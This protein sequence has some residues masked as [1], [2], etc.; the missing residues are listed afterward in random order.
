M[1]ASSQAAGYG[2]QHQDGAAEN[3]QGALH[4]DRGVH[5]TRGIDEVDIVITL[6]AVGGSGLDG[7]PP[8]TLKIHRVHGG[9]D[10]G[11]SFYLFDPVELSGVEGASRCGPPP[12]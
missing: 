1:R 10:A 7:D 12:I 6:D 5:M 4:F 3:A 2:A 8:F 9:I 11:L